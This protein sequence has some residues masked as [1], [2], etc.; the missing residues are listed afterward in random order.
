MTRSEQRWY[1][2][3]LRFRCTRCGDCCRGAGNVW[4]RDEEIAP[5]AAAQK[6]TDDEFRSAYTRQL[7]RHGVLLRQKRNQECVFWNAGSG[8]QVYEQ[9]PHQCRTYP[10][11]QGIV[12][13]PDNWKAESRVCPGIGEGDLH[14]AVDI[15]ETAADDGIPPHRTRRR[16]EGA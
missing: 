10:F 16:L 8:C 3:G 13:S 15:S 2:D 11:W 9:R 1:L 6:M 7:G 14:S 12:H 5:L 4:V